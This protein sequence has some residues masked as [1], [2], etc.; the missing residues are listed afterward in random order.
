MTAIRAFARLSAEL[1]GRATLDL[2]GDGS[3]AYIGKVASYINQAGLDDRVFLRGRCDDMPEMLS[4]YD[5]G[6]TGSRA[7]GFGRVTIEYLAA[8]LKVLATSSGANPEILT[9]SQG[10]IG[11]FFEYG[12]VEGLSRLMGKAINNPQNLAGGG[13]RGIN[14]ASEFTAQRN[15]EGV[16]RVYQEA[17]ASCGL[18]NPHEQQTPGDGDHPRP[19]RREI[20]RRDP[21]ERAD[22]DA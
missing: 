21:E 6:I 11:A 4:H 12:D 9:D 7:E 18:V 20:P 1:R 2:Y 17:L 8:G 15:A 14:R 22:A 13:T 10:E 16:W 3:K 19:Q 5:V